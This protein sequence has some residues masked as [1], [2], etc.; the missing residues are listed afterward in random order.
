MPSIPAGLDPGFRLF[1]GQEVAGD[2]LD[3][4]LPGAV[5]LGPKTT[6]TGPSASTQDNVSCLAFA[7]DAGLPPRRQDLPPTCTKAG[8]RDCGPAHRPTSRLACYGFS[9]ARAGCL[10]RLRRAYCSPRDL[11]CS[12]PTSRQA[13][14]LAYRRAVTTA[15]RRDQ[16]RCGRECAR[17]GCRHV[18]IPAFKDVLS[19]S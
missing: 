13:H 6:M 12:L 10:S 17:P 9:T 3:A 1:E 5:C 7:E 11:I 19:R 8:P 16:S 18:A 15:Y 2:P 14:K 4:R